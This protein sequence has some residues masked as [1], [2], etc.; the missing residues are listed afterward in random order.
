VIA[1]AQVRSRLQARLSARQ[2]QGGV[3]GQ[4]R[5]GLPSWLTCS[6][7]AGVCWAS[8][9]LSCCS[10]W[11]MLLVRVRVCCSSS[12]AALPCRQVSLASGSIPRFRRMNAG[13]R[14]LATGSGHWSARERP[15]DQA[16]TLLSNQSSVGGAKHSDKPRSGRPDRKPTP[17]V[18]RARPSRGPPSRR[19]PMYT[20]TRCFA[21]WLRPH[22]C[23]LARASQLAAYA[24]LLAMLLPSD[25]RGGGAAQARRAPEYATYSA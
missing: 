12:H 23:P 17:A 24:L 5:A 14:R 2:L 19:A 15:I 6:R 16:G 13:S 11:H 21:P 1:G 3:P 10:W 20:R 25:Q 8:C 7:S 9:R 18:A 22:W 4:Q